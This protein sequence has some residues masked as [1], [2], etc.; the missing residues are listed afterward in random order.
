MCL[1]LLRSSFY[2]AEEPYYF[3]ATT[4]FEQFYY[5]ITGVQNIYT[6]YERCI[7]FETLL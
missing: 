5:T 2:L 6:H 1:Y 7:L 3:D 4:T